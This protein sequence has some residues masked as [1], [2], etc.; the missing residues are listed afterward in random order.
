MEQA[1]PDRAPAKML[2]AS[3]LLVLVCLLVAGLWPFHIPSNAVN[4]VENEN[5]LRFE[6]RGS[7]VSASA[8]RTVDSPNDTGYSLEIWLRP[9]RTKGGG[10]ILALDSS[11]APRDPFLLRQY[12]RAIVLQRYLVDQHGNVAHSW[13]KVANVFHAGEGIFVTVTSSQEYTALYVNGVLA[14]TSADPGIAK[15]EITGHLVLANSTVDDSWAGEIS[16]LAIYPRALTPAQVKD[17]FQSWAPDRGPF[18]AGEQLPV[19]LYLFNE[20]AG[21]TVHNLVDSATNLTIPSKYFVLHPAFLRPTWSADFQTR[22]AWHRWSTWQDLAVNIGGFVPF[23]FVFL[24]YFSMAKRSGRSALLVVFL[25]F[26]LSLT[27]EALQRL[28][29]NRDSGMSDVF[30]NTVGTALGVLLYQSAT[31]QALWTRVLNRSP[32]SAEP[33]SEDARFESG[34]DV[35]EKLSLSA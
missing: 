33:E 27:I 13:F 15:Q 11:L 23:G 28:L 30:T 5:G 8:F 6:G 35:H 12:G 3:C 21:S 32:S 14:G 29:P 2:W 1:D 20:R 9:A 31:L 19:A 24:A 17:H 34:S 25:G 10:S 18:L 22:D 26:L 4:W 16:G 7:A